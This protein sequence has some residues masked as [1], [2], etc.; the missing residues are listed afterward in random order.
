M[1]PHAVLLAAALIAGFAHLRAQ[2]AAASAVSAP[3]GVNPPVEAA[4]PPLLQTPPLLPPPAT[5]QDAT[6]NAIATP[7]PVAPAPTAALKKGSAE[8]LRQAIRIRELK[9]QVEEDPEVLTQKAMADCAQ[10][11]EGQRVLMRNY[12]TLL[13]TKMEGLDPSLKPVL[14][15]ELHDVLVRYEQHNVRP[16]VLVEAVDELPGSDS[17]DHC[18]SAAPEKPAKPP[19]RHSRKR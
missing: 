1:K 5:R 6:P 14:E 18:D 9:T 19:K 12:Y 8:Q 4:N 13:Y 15:R 16:S 2:D 10:T 11:P 3:P 7:A 17:A